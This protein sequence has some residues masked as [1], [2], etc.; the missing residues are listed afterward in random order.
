[1]KNSILYIIKQQMKKLT[2]LCNF[3]KRSHNGMTVH[4]LLHLASQPCISVLTSSPGSRRGCGKKKMEFM[5]MSH[6]GQFWGADY[7]NRC[8]TANFRGLQPRFHENASFSAKNVKSLKLKNLFNLP[9]IN[10]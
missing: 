5:W 7:E 10:Q 1:M 2:S 9:A 3:F 8:Y 4:H 6:F